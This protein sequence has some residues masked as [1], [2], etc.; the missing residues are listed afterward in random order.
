[1]KARDTPA[2]FFYDGVPFYH[3][4]VAKQQAQRLQE[5][6]DSKKILIKSLSNYWHFFRNGNRDS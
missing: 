2:F 6:Y 5:V 1:M 3:H 4:P